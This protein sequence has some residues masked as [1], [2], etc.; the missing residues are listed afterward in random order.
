MPKARQKRL[1]NSGEIFTDVEKLRF[2]GAVA[3]MILSPRKIGSRILHRGTGLVSQLPLSSDATPPPEIVQLLRDLLPGNAPLAEFG[4]PGSLEAMLPQ[5]YN[6]LR[7][8]AA[9]YLRRERPNHTLQPTA[10][11]HEVYLQLLGDR[12][13]DWKDRA[14]FLGI[15]ARIMRRIL[16]DSGVARSAL[17]RGGGA[18]HL[19]LDDALQ[20]SVECTVSLRGVDEAL[21]ALE[22]IDP[23]QGRIV[24]LRFFGGLT[25]EEVAEVLQ[26]SVATVKR[27][28]A[29]AKLWLQR[30]LAD[31]A[32]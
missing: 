16:A 22:T 6:E 12:P 25:I 20:F 30:A 23:R 13:I 9:N 32:V 4:N 18:E 17:K 2:F 26:I 10:L 28:W 24:E 27:E 31:D 11:V 19:A 15:S 29:T 5:L 14:H 21:R 1:T 8:L 7:Q 3:P